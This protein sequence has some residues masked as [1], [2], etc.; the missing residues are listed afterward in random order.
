MGNVFVGGIPETA[1]LQMLSENAYTTYGLRKKICS[2]FG[3]E[4]SE[5]GIESVLKHLEKQRLADFELR[6]G[7]RRWRITWIG[8]NTLIAQAVAV[9]KVAGELTVYSEKTMEA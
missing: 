2:V 1:V 5:S 6:F 3:V 8:N 9:Q 7:R 4:L